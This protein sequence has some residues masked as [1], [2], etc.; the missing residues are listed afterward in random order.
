[1]T[2]QQLRLDAPIFIGGAGSSGNTLLARMFS[3]HPDVFCGQEMSLFNKRRIYGDFRTVKRKLPQW[4]WRGLPT[5]GYSQYT[6]FI[7]RVENGLLT[8]EML[9]HA[10]SESQT[11]REFADRIQTRCLTETGKRILAE[12]TPS[13]VYCFRE[14]AA[15]YPN[16]LLIHS[17]RDGRD[18]I[19]SLMKRGYNVFQASSIWLYNAACGIACRD[20]PNYL[21]VRYEELVKDPMGVLQQ[22]CD[23]ASVP[24]DPCMLQPAEGEKVSQ[25]AAKGAWK[26][27]TSGPISQ[28]S[29]G[30]YKTDLS[31]TDYAIFCRVQLTKLGARRTGTPQFTALELSQYLDYDAEPPAQPA[32]ML[33]AKFLAA[34][35]HIRQNLHLLRKAY[36]PRRPLTQICS[37]FSGSAGATL[38]LAAP[39]AIPEP[40]GNLARSA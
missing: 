40:Q 16:C 11:L 29:V 27:S 12:K 9:A 8:H 2:T 17:V 25:F 23:R 5:D 7:P 30:R 14:L 22:V 35:D 33:R 18:V 38:R 34:K 3:R 26:N 24:F 21:E 32:P 4:L 31:D 39:A 28:S 37:T 20:L 10:A 15:L 13:D 19:C 1:M 6:R 36:P